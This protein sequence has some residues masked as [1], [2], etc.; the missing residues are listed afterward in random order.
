MKEILFGN[1]DPDLNQDPKKIFRQ[2]AIEELAQEK[3]NESRQPFAGRH[4]DISPHSIY[5]TDFERWKAENPN[6]ATKV[7]E[8]FPEDDAKQDFE[9]RKQHFE[10]RAKDWFSDEIH[11][12]PYIGETD[13]ERIEREMAFMRGEDVPRDAPEPMYF[14][15]KMSYN[16]YRHGLEFMT[17]AQRYMVAKHLYEKDTNHPD[18]QM[19]SLGDG[20]YTS[21][22][23]IARDLKQ[24]VN[25]EYEWFHRGQ[26]A[27]GGN[28]NA[29]YE[30]ETDI[31]KATDALSGAAFTRR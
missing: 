27:H 28:V 16:G 4:H 22:G 25:S 11:P 5:M 7:T 30:S 17:P 31:P 6:A 13:E 19:I 8:M 24:R 21:A 15:K 14:P 10:S 9:L 18:N 12:E 1:E 29:H 23:R 26:N 20:T 3:T 2:Q